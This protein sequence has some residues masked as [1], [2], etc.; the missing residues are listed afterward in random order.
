MMKE[1]E[2]FS[3]KPVNLTIP[4]SIQYT[5]INELLREKLIGEIISKSNDETKGSN[6]AQILNAS[7]YKSHLE[8]FDLCLELDL[9]TLTSIFK[10][11]QV[12]ILFHAAIELDPS[13]Q[14]VFIS[15]YKIEGKTNSW[16]AD[17]FIETMVN[18]FMYGKLKKKMNYNF[19]PHLHEQIASINEKLEDELEVKEGVYVSGRLG[20][21]KVIEVVALEKDLYVLVSLEG[22]GMIQLKKLKF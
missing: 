19:L 17:Q 6:Y 11:R 3:T 14:Q 1:E 9:Q 4:V 18:N 16:F 12:K 5:A 2:Q 20:E 15:D 10:N 13:Q 21:L 7:V 22:E 8:D